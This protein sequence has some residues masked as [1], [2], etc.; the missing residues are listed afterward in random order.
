ML[1]I[2]SKIKFFAYRD[3]WKIG[4]HT[5]DLYQADN[6]DGNEYYINVSAS[7]D[8]RGSA[9]YFIRGKVVEEPEDKVCLYIVHKYSQYF[10]LAFH[11]QN[12]LPLP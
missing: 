6:G 9:Y 8:M 7:C 10:L 11:P 2:Y 3:D 12:P 4:P 5:G 1:K